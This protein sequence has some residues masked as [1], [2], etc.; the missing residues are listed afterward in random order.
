MLTILKND[1]RKF[2]KN[3]VF[4]FRYLMGSTCKHQEHT[5]IDRKFRLTREISGNINIEL[6][7]LFVPALINI[8]M[9]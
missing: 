9:F 3:L 4:Y 8:Y 5:S 7:S 6:P 2:L 1:L